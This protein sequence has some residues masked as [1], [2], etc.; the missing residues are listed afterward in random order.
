MSMVKIVFWA[1]PILCALM[2][3]LFP[4]S[5]SIRVVSE[6]LSCVG[7]LASFVIVQVLAFCDRSSGFGEVLRSYDLSEQR[8]FWA[9]ALASLILSLLWIVVGLVAITL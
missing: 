7:I 4:L 9:Y 1:A 6:V 8:R 3:I 2:V 5:G